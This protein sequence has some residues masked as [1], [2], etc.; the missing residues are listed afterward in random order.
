MKSALSNQSSAAPS[1]T[2]SFAIRHPFLIHGVLVI[3]CWLTYLLD[4]QDV[5][6]RFI[7]DSPNARSLEH[8]AFACA[9]ACIGLGVWLGAW[10]AGNF[11]GDAGQTVRSIR[12]RSIGEILHVIGIASLLPLAGSVALICAE[13]IRSSLYARS[14]IAASARQDPAPANA[15][16][17]SHNG[18]ILRFLFRHIAGI[19]AFLSMLVFS[20]TLRDRQADTLFAITAAVF[21]IS[22][23]VNVP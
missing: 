20:I 18:L 10:P 11:T 13:A 16:N 1:H 14:R 9:A 23:F 8:L 4:R 2:A 21:V 12:R 17:A 19:C 3:L 5:V 7:K 22:R 15:P 6:W